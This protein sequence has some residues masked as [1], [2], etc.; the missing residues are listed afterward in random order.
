MQ[1][2]YLRADKSTLHDTASIGYDMQG[3]TASATRTT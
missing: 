2:N 1:H 3:R